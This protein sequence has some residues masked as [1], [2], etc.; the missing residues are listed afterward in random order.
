MSFRKIDVSNMYINTLTFIKNESH[1]RIYEKF[2]ES[3]LDMATKTATYATILPDNIDPI[4]FNQLNQPPRRQF[5]ES[6][7]PMREQVV[8]GQN[9]SGKQEK[10]NDV[11]A[12]G[13]V[14]STPNQNPKGGDDLNKHIGSNNRLAYGLLIVCVILL[15]IIG[16]QAYHQWKLNS[17]ATKLQQMVSGG[18]EQ[19]GTHPPT[20]NTAKQSGCPMNQTPATA[21]NHDSGQQ[22]NQMNQSAIRNDRI[23]RQTQQKTAAVQKPRGQSAMSRRNGG[24]TNTDDKRRL[25]TIIEDSEATSDTDPIQ[26]QARAAVAAQLLQDVENRVGDEP[27]GTG[28]VGKCEFSTY[29]HRQDVDVDDHDEALVEAYV[30]GTNHDPDDEAADDVTTTAEQVVVMCSQ[31]LVHGSR[32]GQECGR[33]CRPGKTKCERHF[34]MSTKKSSQS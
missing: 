29:N 22:M 3:I 8:N 6:D 1:C 13:R 2:T 28:S 31:I 18:N 17:E 32:A 9:R 33:D 23:L 27:L 26:E 10:D 34:A 24:C 14:E 20:N 5:S 12:P 30:E 11:N 21:N 16:Y 25:E 19:S 4:G 15:I 7:R